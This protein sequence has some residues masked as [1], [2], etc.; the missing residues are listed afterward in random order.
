[1]QWALLR[2]TQIAAVVLIATAMSIV[3]SIFL[4]R[5]QFEDA[6]SGLLLSSRNISPYSFVPASIIAWL[7]LAPLLHRRT[8]WAVIPVSLVA[9]FLGSAGFIFG[10]LCWGGP[11]G[12]IP[13]T[14]FTYVAW[15]FIIN[16][17][18]IMLPISVLTAVSIWAMLKIGYA[19]AV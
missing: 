3:G 9:P 19:E 13:A 18:V 17:E 5:G 1:M 15:T 16:S 14:G 10:L 7:V 11:L 6:G 12:L 4:M 8:F 2:I